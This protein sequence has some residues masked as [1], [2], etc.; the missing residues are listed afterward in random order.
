MIDKIYEILLTHNRPW[1]FREL[2]FFVIVLMVAT[3][4]FSILL[5]KDK[6]NLFQLIAG[7]LLL[8]FM[9]IVLGS[10]VFT[11][12]PDKVE[13]YKL[14][15]FWSW[16]EVI[17]G[18]IELLEENLLNFLLLFPFGF[19]LPFVFYKK[20]SWNKAFIMGLAFSFFIETS[21]L[22]LHRGLFEWDDMIHNSIG[23]ML[24]CIIANKIFEKFVKKEK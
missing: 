9:F 19:L 11:R 5:K 6:M 23:A 1:S 24:G 22:I 2:I 8:I 17:K 20:I 12:V 21:Q 14:M 18:D 16:N 13:A 15:P 3:I 7:E 10:T 4:I